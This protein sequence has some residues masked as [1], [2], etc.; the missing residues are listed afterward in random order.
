MPNLQFATAQ[1][2]KIQNIWNRDQGMLDDGSYFIATN[3]TPGTGITMGITASE[4]E[5]KPQMLLYNSWGVNDPNGKN[6][7]PVALRI[8]YVVAPTSATFFQMSIHMDQNNPLKYTSGGSLIVPTNAGVATTASKATI[9]FGAITAL[10]STLS[11]GHLVANQMMSP[12]IPLA[13]DVQSI[14]WGKG[15][16]G[17]I[18][19][20][21]SVNATR[22]VS[23]PPMSIP[24]GAWMGIQMWGT[25]YATTAATME[26]QFE[27]VER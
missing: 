1:A 26:F 10:A 25:S 3:P 7:Y 2:Q 5:T 11:G 8:T 16:T 24:P 15:I 12:T 21:T 19:N 14:E 18:I 9:Y 23:L 20:A 27:Y 13:K 4:A 17:P 22:T 6:I